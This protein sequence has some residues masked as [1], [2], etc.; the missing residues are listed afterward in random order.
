MSPGGAADQ[1]EQRSGQRGRQGKQEVKPRQHGNGQPAVERDRAAGEQQAGRSAKP[2]KA[3]GNERG[4]QDGDAGASECPDRTDPVIG[5]QAVEQMKVRGD[6]GN[7]M[8]GRQKPGARHDWIG[9]DHHGFVFEPFGKLPAV[10]TLNRV[11][12]GGQRDRR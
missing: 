9:K 11:P 3:P 5:E 2:Q 7:R 10:V 1:D 4:E 12:D 6:A 8:A